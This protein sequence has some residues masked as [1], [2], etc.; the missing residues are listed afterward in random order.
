MHI[1]SSPLASVRTRPDVSSRI[2]RMARSS[3]FQ[4]ASE[5]A[6]CMPVEVMLP[7]HEPHALCNVATG[8]LRQLPPPSTS[9]SSLGGLI[10]KMP[11]H[12]LNNRDPDDRGEALAT[13][14]NS[15]TWDHS[16]RNL[17]VRLRYC[18]TRHTVSERQAPFTPFGSGRPCACHLVPD[19]RTRRYDDT[20]HGISKAQ[21]MYSASSN[22]V[23]MLLS[24][25]ITCRS[26]TKTAV[27]WLFS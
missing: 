17:D 13:W 3:P 15:L 8:H 12:N 14:P 23:T 2:P 25:T 19:T 1:S 16:L 18:L 24:V 5:R 7:L 4:K 27:K 20:P 22:T 9:G 11:P 10:S 21:S 26:S 6:P